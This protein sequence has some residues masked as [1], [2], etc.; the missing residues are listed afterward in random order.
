MLRGLV[1][2]VCLILPMGAAAQDAQTLADIKQELAVLLVEMQKLKRELS[3]T[4]GSGVQVAGSTLDRV[5]AIERELQRL[6]SQTERLDGRIEAVVADGTNRIGDL[7]FRICEL[8][9][10]CDIGTLGETAPIGGDVGRPK[11]RPTVAQQAASSETANT[12]AQL[13]LGEQEEFDRA[14]AAYDS[15][16][17]SSAASLFDAYTTNYAGGPLAGEA[18]FMRGEALAELGQVSDAARAYLASFSGA[19]EGPKAPDALFKL[20]EALVVLGQTDQA[21]ITLGEVRVRY[22]ATQAAANANGVLDRLSC[23]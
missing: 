12:G 13:A 23:L 8:E 17:W 6:T 18:H 5:D 1:L 2:S 14:R 7:E 15:G 20:G 10:G 22:P 4:G 11:A 21:C 16:N 19:P 9:T 3:T